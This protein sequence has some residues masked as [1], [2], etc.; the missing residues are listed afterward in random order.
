MKSLV[1]SFCK[2][3]A[4]TPPDAMLRLFVGTWFQILFHSPRRGSFHL[5]LTVLVHYRSKEVFSLGRWSSQIPT[6]FLVSRGT[7]VMLHKAKR[8]FTYGAITL[9]GGPFQVPSIKSFAFYTLPKIYSSSW[10]P[11]INPSIYSGLI[12]KNG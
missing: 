6:R 9:Y 4:V 1:G 2:K 5:S 3:H 7:R 11:V 12:T 8:F 10:F